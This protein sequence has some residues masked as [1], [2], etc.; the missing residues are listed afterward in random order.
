[1]GGITSITGPIG[2]GEGV[3]VGAGVSVSNGFVSSSIVLI[4]VSLVQAV[5][6][7]FFNY[8]TFVYELTCKN[9][10]RIKSSGCSWIAPGQIMTIMLPVI[11]PDLPERGVFLSIRYDQPAHAATLALGYVSEYWSG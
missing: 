5:V 9:L 2:A 3:G 10:V 1:V 11:A 6:C 7:A 8:Q 4:I